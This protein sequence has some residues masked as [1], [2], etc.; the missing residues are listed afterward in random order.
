M[1]SR[2][3]LIQQKQH[4]KSRPERKEIS[5]SLTL[6]PPGGYEHLHLSFP[7]NFKPCLMSRQLCFNGIC[8]AGWETASLIPRLCASQT[9]R[10]MVCRLVA[11][12]SE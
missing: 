10:G 4:V 3:R 1:S 12:A 5:N 11:R 6:V 2:S 8:L 9:G 7:W